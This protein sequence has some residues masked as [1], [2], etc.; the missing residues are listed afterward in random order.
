MI[1]SSPSLL[2]KNKSTKHITQQN[3]SIHTE[4]R[5]LNP[6]GDAVICHS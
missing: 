6:I 1:L 4:N 3:L 5:A 2:N